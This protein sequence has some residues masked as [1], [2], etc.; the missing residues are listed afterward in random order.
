MVVAL[1]TVAVA[2][3]VAVV[4]AVAVAVAAIERKAAHHTKPMPT[5]KTYALWVAY[6]CG[7][8]KDAIELRV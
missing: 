2:V 8:C 7:S 4:V 6:S 3:A 5:P 1:V